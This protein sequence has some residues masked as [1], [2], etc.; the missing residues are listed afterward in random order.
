MSV[1][2]KT[3]ISFIYIPI[4][5]QRDFSMYSQSKGTEKADKI[6]FVGNYGVCI[7]KD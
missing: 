5:T 4:I 3:N 6:V 7:F 2:Q 1:A